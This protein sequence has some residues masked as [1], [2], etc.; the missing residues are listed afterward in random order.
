MDAWIWD[1]R[2][3]L[4]GLVRSPGFAF[5]AVLTL[6]L[7]IG[8]NTAIFSLLDEVFLRPLPVR[9]PEE[10]VQVVVPRAENVEVDFSYPEFLDIAGREGERRPVAASAVL[11]CALGAGDQALHLYG[12]RVSGNYLGLLG[13]PMAAGRPL[14]PTDDRP[15]AAYVVVLGYDLWRTHFRADPGVVGKPIRLDQ[16]TATVVGVAGKGF[17]GILRGFPTSLWVPFHTGQAIT[18]ET[19][20]LKSRNSRWVSVFAR[21][22]PERRVALR[23][24]LMLGWR[25][26]REERSANG[27][28]LL[29]PASRGDM[30]LL[31]GPGRLS[32]MLMALVLVLLAI[33]SANVAGLLMARTEGRRR[34]IAIRLALGSGTARLARQFML[35]SLS[36]AALGGVLG[37]LVAVWTIDLLKAFTPPSPWPLDLSY[38]IDGRVLLFGAVVTVFTGL[39]FG[40]APVLQAR[41]VDLMEALKRDAGAGW[42]SRRR[43]DPRRLLVAG[44]VALSVL[45]LTAAGLFLR[46]LWNERA[47]PLGFDPGGRLAVSLD[48]GAAG[49]DRVA[50]QLFYHQ[51]L[52]RVRAL[53]GVESASL[54]QYLPLSIGGSAWGFVAGELMPGAPEIDFNVNAVGDDFFRTTGIRLASGREF[55]LDESFGPQGS[56]KA[57]VDRALAAR[58][59]PGQ[60]PVGRFLPLPGP[61]PPYEIVA[62]AEPARTRGL[63]GPGRPTLYLSTPLRQSRDL[64]LIVRTDRRAGL[65]FT[66]IAT[67]VAELNPRVALFEPIT[68]E[69]QVA[70]ATVESRFGALLMGAFG[71]LALGLTSLGLYGLLAFAV[72]RRTRE[73]GLRLAFGATPARVLRMIVAESFAIS[74]PGFIVGLALALGLSRLVASLLYGVSPT[75]PWTYVAMIGLMSLALLTAAWLPGRRAAR[76]EPMVALREE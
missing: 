19:E 25:E 13:A 1:L 30:S 24:S 52:D 68:L 3:A 57:V 17:R 59:W 36:L 53:P 29:R 39:A 12:E 5:V 9:S 43:F 61:Q 75:D 46:T 63:R 65:P 16:T 14:T 54:S 71:L 22:A 74:L 50:A 60:N 35:E 10:L 8:A 34:E 42:W 27:T 38:R 72:A 18:G 2:H 33:A 56:H 49:L 55:T 64:A 45:L 20:A 67:V 6:A 41:R 26:G 69:R 31:D 4:R 70:Q 23:Q 44:Q 47:V 51:L 66:A 28:L 58:L 76:L 21:V 11:W 37:M 73:I 15:D 62:V 7:G 40:L 32:R 48:L